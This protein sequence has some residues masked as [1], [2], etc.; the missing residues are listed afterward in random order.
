MPSTVVTRAADAHAVTLRLQQHEDQR[1]P[2]GGRAGAD[3]CQCGG[4][5]AQ[6]QDVQ[7]KQRQ[8]QCERAAD[9][10]RGFVPRQSQPLESRRA[11]QQREHN[12]Q[13]EGTQRQRS[14]QDP[15]QHHRGGDATFQH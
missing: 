14:Q 5:R 4:T 2:H 13:R 6:A 10:G 3:H 9:A 7:H 12:S 11:D 15:Q 8:C 1:Q